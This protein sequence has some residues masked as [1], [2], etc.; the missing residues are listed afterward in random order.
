MRNL[1]HAEPVNAQLLDALTQFIRKR[2]N[3]NDICRVRGFVRALCRQSSVASSFT[4][5][6]IKVAID[7]LMVFGFIYCNPK[8]VQDPLRARYWIVN[9]YIAKIYWNAKRQRYEALFYR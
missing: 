8:N 7:L 5:E 1:L 6:Q 3:N 2:Q 4:S 9:R